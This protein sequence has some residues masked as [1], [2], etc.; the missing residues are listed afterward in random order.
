M[1]Y[2]FFWSERAGSGSSGESRRFFTAPWKDQ[3]EDQ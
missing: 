2:E 3:A 1:A